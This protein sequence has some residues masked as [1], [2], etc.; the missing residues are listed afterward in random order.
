MLWIWV[1]IGAALGQTVRG[2]YQKK[3]KAPLGDLGASYV[4][5]SYALPFAWAWVAV[6]AIWSGE[7]LPSVTFTFLAWTTVAGVMQIIF[8]VLLV[9]M[10]SHRS[11]AAGTAFSKTEVIQAAIFE[12][13]ILGY[14]V[15]LQVGIAIVIGVV[16]V[17]LLSLAKSKLTLGNLR[18]SLFTRQT[19]IGLGS[20][21]SLGFCTVAYRAAIDTLESDDLVTRAGVT[22]AVAVLIQAL[23]MGFWL[24]RRAPD[25]LRASFVHW[26]DS[27][28]V[29]FSELSR[30]PAGS[31]LFPFMRLRLC[32]PSGRSKSCS[33]LRFPLSISARGPRRKNCLRCCF[34]RSR[35]L[36]CFLAEPFVCYQ[37]L[38]W[39]ATKKGAH[40]SYW[41]WTDLILSP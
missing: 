16:A 3:L 41:R 28:I 9:T 24:W 12:A 30:P 40:S 15:S 5:F 23:L 27:S 31:P 10:F 32:V 26:R 20:G 17:F 35:L 1:T 18:E 34:S 21:A 14:I 33:S 11:F 2:A 6:Y 25:Q 38:G 4:R 39:P 13:L 19:A 37:S 22:A 8:T 29:G 36:W 7:P